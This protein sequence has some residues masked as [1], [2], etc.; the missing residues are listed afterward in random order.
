M[1][2]VSGSA[3]GK[4]SFGHVTNPVILSNPRRNSPTGPMGEYLLEIVQNVSL[5]RFLGFWSVM[6]M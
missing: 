6:C 4:S 1:V 2:I 5:A 3:T